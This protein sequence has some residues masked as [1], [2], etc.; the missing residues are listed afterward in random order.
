MGVWAHIEIHTPDP[1]FHG[2]LAVTESQQLADLLAGI[3]SDHRLKLNSTMGAIE[4]VRSRS[5]VFSEE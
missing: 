2:R 1:D 3:G 4:F 5:K